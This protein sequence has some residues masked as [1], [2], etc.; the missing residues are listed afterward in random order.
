MCMCVSRTT[1]LVEPSTYFMDPRSAHMSML[2][3]GCMRSK[4]CMHEWEVEPRTRKGV[5]WWAVDFNNG[6]HY[7]LN[8]VSRH[9]RWNWHSHLHLTHR[10]GL[11]WCWGTYRRSYTPLASKRVGLPMVCKTSDINLDSLCVCTRLSVFFFFTCG[12]YRFTDRLRKRKSDF[13]TVC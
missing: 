5:V 9:W 6:L 7:I 1:S 3:P 13:S 10:F 11:L 2:E 12:E 4:F 8:I